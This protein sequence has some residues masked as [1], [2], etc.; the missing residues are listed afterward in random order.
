[1]T[2]AEGVDAAPLA[3]FGTATVAE[4]CALAR[5]LEAPPRPLSPGMRAAG[6]ALTVRTRPGDNLA[7]HRAMAI[8]QPGDVLVVESGQDRSHGPFGEIMAL[9]CQMRGIAA[10]VIDGTVRD[11]VA[12]SALGFP[13]FAR[14][15]HI[16]GTTKA[17][18]GEIG[19]SVTIGG[20]VIATGDIVVADADG[21]IVLPAQAL[22]AA[23][24]AARR[25]AENEARMME[26]LRAGETTLQILGLE[27]A[28]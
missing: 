8:A 3:A 19:G 9:A 25:R 24:A 2:K 12:I 16:R 6:R 5:I 21:V 7:L 11:S 23:L 15:L 20:N 10:L 14:G 1:M 18:E 17:D 4:A 27:G 13:V 22:D 28:G 26:R